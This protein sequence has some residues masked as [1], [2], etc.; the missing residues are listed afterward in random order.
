MK[1]A[2][3]RVNEASTIEVLMEKNLEMYDFVSRAGD[4][5]L[6]VSNGSKF[7]T[8]CYYMIAVKGDPNVQ[9]E[10]A[11]VRQNDSIGL[12]TYGILKQSLKK[13]E[14]Y[15]YVYYSIFDFNLSIPLLYGEL[16]VTIL[17][18]NKTT[19]YNQSIQLST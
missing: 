15:Q 3:N 6:L 18:P 19:F 11:I 16:Q 14:K 13:G 7:C 9:A 8:K 10:M 12:T 5:F 1:I 2:V 17:T 4:S